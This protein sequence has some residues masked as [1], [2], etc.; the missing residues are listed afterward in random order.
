M[1][2]SRL[3]VIGDVG[4]Y[5]DSLVAQLNVLGVDVEERLI[6]PELVVC[7]VGDLVHKG[8]ESAAVVAL[9]D[10]LMARNPDR[11]I[12]LLGNHEAQY[13]PD[14]QQFWTPAVDE[15]TAQTIRR[16]WD[17]GQVRIAAAF[18]VIG[19]GGDGIAVDRC[20]PGELIVTHAGV[21]PGCWKLLGEPD[22]VS[23]LV[24]V[25][26]AAQS[27]AV[28]RAGTLLGGFEDM[29]AGPL[30]AVAASELYR[31]WALLGEDAP[32]RQV[33]AFNQAHGH[34]AARDWRNHR[35]YQ[36]LDAYRMN[37]TASARADERRRVT[38][39]QIGD[40][41]FFGTDPSS[42]ATAVPVSEPLV[43]TIRSRELVT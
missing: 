18:D 17:K 3:A 22:S 26:N 20:P 13:L 28:W 19:N 38:R 7:Q 41:V 23:E 39:V 33:P 29:S 43:L 42:D 4:G 11:W 16:W 15:K 34:T 5:L 8:P 2:D 36:P 25:L 32:E 40:R 9:V 31:S 27:P 10:E 21:T 12:Q 14:C 1:T 30:W 37:G 24:A 6:P 35:W